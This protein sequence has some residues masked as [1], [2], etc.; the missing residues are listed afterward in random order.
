MVGSHE[1]SNAMYAGGSTGL[2]TLRRDGFAS[3]DAGRGGG[4]LTTRP[5]TFDGRFLFVNADAGGGELRAEA[6]DEEGRV[7]SSFS[8]RECAPTSSDATSHRMTWSGGGDLS[9][10]RGRPVRFRFH[11]SG[12][13]LYAFWVSRDAGGAS[14]GHPAA[15]GPGLSGR[16]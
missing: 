3:M 9:A 4:T 6:L 1:A 5:V 8:A 14:N 13:R 15:G 16:A 7:L 2:A 11:L 12:G 10:L